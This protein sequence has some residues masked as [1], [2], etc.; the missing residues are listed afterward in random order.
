MARLGDHPN[1]VS[2][3][4]VGT[5]GRHDLHRRAVRARRLARRPD[6]NAAAPAH[7]RGAGAR[8]GAR[9]RGGAGPRARA[10]R[11]PPRR[12]AGQRALGERD[13]ALLTDFGVAH[14][15]EDLRLTAEHA[16]VGTVPYMPPEQA[17]GAPADPRSDLYALGVMLFELLLRRAAVHRP[18]RAGDPAPSTPAPR[19]RAWRRA[20][21]AIAPQLDALVA[22][23]MAIDPAERPQSAAALLERLGAL[24]PDGPAPV[25]PRPRRP[26]RRVRPP[27][28]GAGGRATGPVRRPRRAA[29]AL[30]ETWRRAVAGE[31]GVVLV[32][33]NAGIGKTR[34]CTQFAREAH[35]DGGTVLY[36]RCEEEALAPYGPFV[37]A[38]RH[39]AAHQPALPEELAAARRASSSRGSAGP[40]RARRSRRPV[41]G[42]GPRGR[43]LPAVRGRGHARRRDGGPGAAAGDLRRPALGRRADAADAPPPRPVRRHDA[44]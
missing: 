22:Q 41:A 3:Y 20:I 17:R 33:G 38:L 21:P 37:E 35:A 42:L 5:R 23:L 11:R 36:G 4:D 12:Q 2:V 40:C 13:V 30:R 34:L 39:F 43:P 8:G 18:G 31:P 15:L 19:A 7:G 9:R 32:R 44:R 25:P 28:A 26:L 6:A 10:R 24:A 29:R 16:H 14:T 27:A 1:V